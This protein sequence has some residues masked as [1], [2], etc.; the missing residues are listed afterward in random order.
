MIRPERAKQR[1]TGDL[2][3]SFQ[4]FAIFTMLTQG[5]ALG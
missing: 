1:T 5:V 4:G 2:V 3:S